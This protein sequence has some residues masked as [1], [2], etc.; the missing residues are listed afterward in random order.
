[1]KGRK[2]NVNISQGANV[3]FSL[4]GGKLSK[5]CYVCGYQNSVFRE[6]PP[7]GNTEAFQGI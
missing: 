5:E 2:S 6:G 3:V 7:G 4:L 1:M